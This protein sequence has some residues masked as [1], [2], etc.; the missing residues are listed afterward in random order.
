MRR[1]EDAVRQLAV[2]KTEYRTPPEPGAE[3]AERDRLSQRYQA[4]MDAIPNVPERKFVHLKALHLRKVELSRILSAH[5][6]M[7]ARQA[8]RELRRRLKQ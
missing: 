4:V 7:T 8:R 5:P 2:L 3:V 1:H 6:G